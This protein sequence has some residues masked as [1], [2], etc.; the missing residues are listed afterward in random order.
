MQASLLAL[1]ETREGLGEF[2]N[3]ALIAR[4]DSPSFLSSLDFYI[5]STSSR[6]AGTR[7]AIKYSLCRCFFFLLIVVNLKVFSVEIRF[8]LYLIDYLGF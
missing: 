4:D 1:R 7:A 8:F 6:F 2:S 5:G 3:L